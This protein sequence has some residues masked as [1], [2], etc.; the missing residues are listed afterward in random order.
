MNLEGTSWESS[1]SRE[2]GRQPLEEATI[3]GSIAE[4]FSVLKSEWT[5]ILDVQ[6]ILAK[7]DSNKNI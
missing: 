2:L 7:S 3:K 6:N 1:G 4:K 5:Y